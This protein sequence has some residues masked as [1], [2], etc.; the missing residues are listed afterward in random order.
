MKFPKGRKDYAMEM[1]RADRLV[2]IGMIGVFIVVIV[3]L[4]AIDLLKGGPLSATIAATTT[5]VGIIKVAILGVCLIGVVLGLLMWV[6]GRSIPPR[7]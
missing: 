6:W 4:V 5:T 2:L 1:R 3:A 7:G